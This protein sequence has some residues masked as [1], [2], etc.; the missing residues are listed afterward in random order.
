MC[1]LRGITIASGLAHEFTCGPGTR[2]LPGT[3]IA[4][5]MARGFIGSHVTCIHRS[6]SIA[7]GTAS[8]LTSRRGTRRCDA[9]IMVTTT[10]GS[11]PA[12]AR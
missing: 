11:G 8:A 2:I 5:G 7:S 3:N 6:T 1:I 10:T 4:S 9:I 12:L